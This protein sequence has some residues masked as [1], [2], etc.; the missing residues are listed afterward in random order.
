MKE[1]YSELKINEH[2]TVENENW[3]LNSNICESIGSSCQWMIK[4]I[5][6]VDIWQ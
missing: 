6:T 2:G 1:N 4:E 5:K 3:L